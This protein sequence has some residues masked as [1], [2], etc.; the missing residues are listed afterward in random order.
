MSLNFETFSRTI[1]TL[2][3]PENSLADAS[4]TI[5]DIVG[6]F[7]AFP[8]GLNKGTHETDNG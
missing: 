7:I 8:R 6:T 3:C 4:L 2:L 1:D 5:F